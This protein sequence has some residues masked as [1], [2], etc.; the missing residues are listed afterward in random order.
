MNNIDTII[1]L[2]EISPLLLTLL[3][4]VISHFINI[5]VTGSIGKYARQINYVMSFL[6]ALGITQVAYDFDG[7]VMTIIATLVLGTLIAKAASGEY[8][9]AKKSIL[10]KKDDELTALYSEDEHG[11]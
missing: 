6:F 5:W 2:T 8:N 10:D 11:V 9:E 1:A 7:I 4:T 3:A